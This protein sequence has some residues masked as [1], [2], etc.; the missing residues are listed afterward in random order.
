MAKISAQQQLFDELME[1]YGRQVAEAFFRALDELRSGVELQRVAAAI[2]NGDIEAALEALHIEPSAFAELPEQVRQAFTEAG[3]VSAQGLPKRRPDGTALVVRFDGT[4]PQAERWLSSHSSQLVTRITE[5][6]RQTVRDRLVVGMQKGQNPRAVALDIVGRINRVTGKREGG[7]LGL[8]AQQADFV[9]SARAELSDPTTME[10]FLAR[11]RR[12]KRFDR[13]ISKA[14]REG[15]PLPTAMHEKIVT[16]YSRRLLQL[17]GETIG[18][19][20]ALTSLNAGAYQA[21]RQ[22]VDEGKIPANAVRRI[23]RSARDRR[24]RDTHAALDSDA[25]GLDEAFRSPSGALLRFPGD[26]SLGAPARE[27]IA[28]RCI[29]QNRVDWLANLA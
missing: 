14:A 4:N 9:E 19:T 29:V 11:A 21:I 28:C 13:T 15:A 5:E 12:D 16:A 2:E 10:Q 18:R 20:E 1:R 17:R 26:T 3:R 27:I 22:A 6:Q 8:T 25:V 24:V 7:V 23:W